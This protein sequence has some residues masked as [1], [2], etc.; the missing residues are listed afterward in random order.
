MVDTYRGD[1]FHAVNTLGSA[2]RAL[3]RM[4]GKGRLLLLVKAVLRPLEE[5]LEEVRK[6]ERE[7]NKS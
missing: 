3:E 5:E 6:S 7:A 1:L 2:K 4:E